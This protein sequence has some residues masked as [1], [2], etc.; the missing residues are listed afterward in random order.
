MLEMLWM[1]FE[2]YKNKPSLRT[3]K[4]DAYMLECAVL[5]DKEKQA[6]LIYKVIKEN[7]DALGRYTKFCDANGAVGSDFHSG[8]CAA[9]YCALERYRQYKKDLTDMR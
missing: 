7:A 5:L 8:S 3:V 1:S 9:V 4:E 2:A 6:D